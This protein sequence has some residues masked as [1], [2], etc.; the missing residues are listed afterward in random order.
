VMATLRR[1]TRRAVRQA[2]PPIG[3]QPA[4]VELLV[5]VVETP[6]IAVSAAAETL[7]LAPNTVSTLVSVLLRAG[8]IERGTDGQDRRVASLR[9]SKKGST[10][11]REWIAAR[12][13]VVDEALASLDGADRAA[14]AAAVGPLQRLTTVLGADR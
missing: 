2:V 4:A 11:V 9:P 3:I 5:L 7:A 1:S 14:I 10:R 6:G 12:Q 13:R 8:L